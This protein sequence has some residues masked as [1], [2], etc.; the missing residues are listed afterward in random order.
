MYIIILS[1]I[2]SGCLWKGPCSANDST[3]ILWLTKHF[4]NAHI[5]ELCQLLLLPSTPNH[6]SWKSSDFNITNRNPISCE[7]C[8]N[9][10]SDSDRKRESWVSAISFAL[11]LHRCF[12]FNIETIAS[13]SLRTKADVLAELPVPS[14]P[15]SCEIEEKHPMHMICF[16]WKVM[17]SSV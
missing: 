7:P 3:F 14:H 6:T 1:M 4:C 13:S 17:F 10:S 2:L 15:C 5:W 11:L 8:M 16:T 9:W 12:C